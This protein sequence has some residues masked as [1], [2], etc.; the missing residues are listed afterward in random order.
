[1]NTQGGFVF[2][3]GPTTAR[4]QSRCAVKQNTAKYFRIVIGIC[5]E[6]DNIRST[7]GWTAML[8]KARSK[9]KDVHCNETIVNKVGRSPTFNCFLQLKRSDLRS[10]WHGFGIDYLG[11]L[12]FFSYLLD[13]MKLLLSVKRIRD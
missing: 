4:G 6:A 2:G 11:Y 7:S 5:R 10:H 9:K 13:R 8:L 12:S 3:E 1:M